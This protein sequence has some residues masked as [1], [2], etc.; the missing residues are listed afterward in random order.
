VIQVFG[1]GEIQYAD[2]PTVLLADDQVSERTGIRYA[3]EHAGFSVV[4]EAVDARG[5]V[6][7]AL[8]HRPQVCLLDVDMPGGGVEAADRIVAQLP[9]TKIAM[10]WGSKGEPELVAAIRAGADGFLLRSTPPDRVSVA[11]TALLHGE[12]TLPRSLTGLL[13]TEVRRP[14]GNGSDRVG[15]LPVNGRKVQQRSS[16]RYWMLYA[17]RFLRHFARRAS[18][19][20]VRQA[21]TSA[22]RRMADY[23]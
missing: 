21:W 4:A 2:G 22:R 1:S 17:P 8:E 3:L 16:A 14:A 7:A 9:T 11:L 13:V 20:T 18:G 23:R 10:L 15:E 12:A 6:A 5:A 19:M